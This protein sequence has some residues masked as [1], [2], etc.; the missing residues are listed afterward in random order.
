[1]KNHRLQDFIYMNCPEYKLI[2]TESRLITTRCWGFGEWGVIANGQVMKIF[3]S[4]SIGG[5][6]ILLKYTKN[7][8]SNTLGGLIVWHMNYISI[9]II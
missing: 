7:I 8:D 3:W 6:I 9:K 2:L 5:C 4:Y 1:M